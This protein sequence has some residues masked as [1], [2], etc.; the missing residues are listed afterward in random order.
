MRRID[1]HAH[2]THS[3][4]TC[5]PE[6]LV[7]RAVTA[8]LTA[9]AVTDHDT[10]S[11]LDAARTAARPHG[12]E[13]LSGVEVSTQIPEGGVHVLGYGFDEA[14]ETF[15]AFLEHVRHERARRNEQILG[16]LEALGVPLT[17]EEVAAH[18]TG[19]IVA[20]PHFAHAM[21][22][23][24]YVESFREAFDRYLS[25][26]GPAY[27]LADL[28]TPEEAIVAIRKGGGV[29]V[30]AHP[31]QI[32]IEGQARYVE[33]LQRLCAA[34]LGGLEVQHPSHKPHHRARF[35]KLAERFGLVPTGGSDFHGANKPY[36]Q[37]G[38]G[39]GTI[40]VGYETWDRLQERCVR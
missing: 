27:V 7:E 18:A 21:V 13:I 20:R 35:L 34:G 28:P 12:L 9:L 2:T 30:L 23:R 1:L 6:E 19:S 8:G 4:G 32:S 14:S 31:R 36:I 29:A 16:R 22:A 3:D 40:E 37:L 15:R 38:V 26:A 11:G 5:L 33:L 39:D 10:T 25:D 24:G 17:A